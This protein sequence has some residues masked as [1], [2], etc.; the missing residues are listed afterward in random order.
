MSGQELLKRTLQRIDD[1]P[2]L[3]VVVQEIISVTNR[4]DSN[5][6]DLIDIINMDTS[7]T[8]N[9]LKVA[10]SPVFG[11]PQQIDSTRKA[12]VLLGFEE[13]RNIALSAGVFAGLQSEEDES[14]FAQDAYWRHSF[15][16]AYLA[17]ELYRLFPSQKQKSSYFTAGLLHDIGY[18]VLGQHFPREL[19]F[20]T[21][22]VQ[23]QKASQLEAEE[24]FL[25]ATHSFIGGS[26]LQRWQLPQEQINAV[27]EHHSPWQA[28]GEK[29]LVTA[30]Y[31]ANIAAQILG[32]NVRAEQAAVTLDSF[33]GSSDIQHL[34]QSGML[35]PRKQFAAEISRL[36]KN[37]AWLAEVVK[38]STQLR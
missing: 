34:E 3:P 5:A 7:L 1:L 35:L 38:H 24:K 19:K 27:M 12:V 25:G 20:I 13:V 11:L 23:H 21:E 26:L 32:Y 9:L 2:T 16:V 22:L 18:V 6:Q 29:E 33:Y 10:N 17:R 37:E 15:L 14:I 30:V 36:Q 28:K 31:Y 4:E 8:A